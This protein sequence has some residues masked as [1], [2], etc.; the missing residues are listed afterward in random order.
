MKT[1]AILAAASAALAALAGFATMQDCCKPG[2]EAGPAV[3]AAADPSGVQ[4][5]TVVVDGGFKPSTINV[6]AGQPVVLTFDTRQ[7]GCATSVSFKSLGMSKD[8][9]N[10]KKTVVTFTPKR[11]GEFSFACPMGMYSGKVVAK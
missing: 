9:A 2:K 6:K 4:K 8:L 1:L 5:A 10:G 11:P 7:R 3:P